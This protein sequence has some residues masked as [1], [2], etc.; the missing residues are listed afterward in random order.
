MKRTLTNSANITGLQNEDVFATLSRILARR[1]GY[2]V[3][4]QKDLAPRKLP[5]FSSGNILKAD[6]Y[7]EGKPFAPHGFVISAKYQEVGG[8]ADSKVYYEVDWIIKKC[9]P[10]PSILLVRGEHWLSEPR[11]RARIWLK[12]QIDQRWLRDVF[13]SVDELYTWAGNLPDCTGFT[14]NIGPNNSPSMPM[15]DLLHQSTFF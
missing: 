9:M 1:K 12:E 10:V 14:N 6:F 3:A 5:I 15:V 11:E 4:T 2:L 8:T 13:F 7:F